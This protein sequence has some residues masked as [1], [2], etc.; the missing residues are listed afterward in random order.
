M[1]SP[2]PKKLA[3]G[4]AT[5]GGA[6]L[7]PWA[8]GTAGSLVAALIFFGTGRLPVYA[9]LL[10]IAAFLPIG[11]WAATVMEQ[12]SHLHDDG[13]IV[14]DEV[15][16]MWITLLGFPPH[17]LWVL[18]GFLVFRALD[19]VKPFPAN[20]IDRTWPGAKGVVFDDIVSGI[21]SLAVMHAI[22]RI[23]VLL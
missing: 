23:S 6:G 1:T 14:I 9:Q 3:W 21:Y 17:W 15:L 7:S 18:I 12:E 19:I 4:I 10:I 13:R 16:G 22:W 5:A 20:W 8:S 2:L 11:L